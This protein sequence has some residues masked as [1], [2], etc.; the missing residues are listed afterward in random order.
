MK[1]TKHL[2][3]I[4]L[5]VLAFLVISTTNVKAETYSIT[6]TTEAELIQAC[7]TS[8]Q[9]EDSEII[10]GADILLTESLEIPVWENKNFDLNGHKL[11]SQDNN[12]VLTISYGWVGLNTRQFNF[13]RF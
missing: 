13:Y 2:L 1:N 5:I 7:D 9:E 11:E 6:V 8:F 12:V 3:V 4:L 10:L